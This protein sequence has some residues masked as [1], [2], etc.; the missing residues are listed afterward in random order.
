MVPKAPTL[1]GPEPRQPGPPPLAPTPPSPP[2]TSC[3]SPPPPPKKNHQEI[4][5]PPALREV[6]TSLWDFVF[7]WRPRLTQTATVSVHPPLTPTWREEEIS[8]PRSRVID[9]Q[10]TRTSLHG[11]WK[12]GGGGGAEV[13]N[14][15][16]GGSQ[17]CGS[18]VSSEA[19]FVPWSPWSLGVGVVEATKANQ[20]HSIGS[21]WLHLL[22]HV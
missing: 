18:R 12:G 14:A 19:I 1:H 5:K 7:F 15:S 11:P 10:V 9:A 17:V 6:K 2:R 20:K 16:H 13:G 4:H 8:E 22:T 21:M 3:Q